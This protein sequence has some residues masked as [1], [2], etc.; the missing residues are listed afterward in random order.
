MQVR[1]LSLIDPAPPGFT[2]GHFGKR[3]LLSGAIVLLTPSSEAASALLD[4][5]ES[6]AEGIL[7][8]IG[9][10]SMH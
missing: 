2:C 9:E 6:R 5:F 10:T 4:S 7:L 3:E 8:S 1:F